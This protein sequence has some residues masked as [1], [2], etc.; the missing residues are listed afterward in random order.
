MELAGDDAHRQRTE[1]LGVGRN[2]IPR[3][4]LNRDK[5][6]RNVNQSGLDEHRD[7]HLLRIGKTWHFR[8]HHR[9]VIDWAVIVGEQMRY[10]T[11]IARCRT[12]ANAGFTIDGEVLV[13]GHVA[14]I[15]EHCHRDTG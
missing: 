13:P 12:C 3:K 8:R 2:A 14:I 10:K 6:D 15:Y 11:T 9:H 4:V 5:L 7:R 1:L